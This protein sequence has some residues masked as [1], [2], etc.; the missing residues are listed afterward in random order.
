LVASFAAASFCAATAALFYQC[1]RF[2]LNKPTKY[3]GRILLLS[4]GLY[5]LFAFA[6]IVVWGFYLLILNTRDP[7]DWH[8]DEVDLSGVAAMC[9]ALSLWPAYGAILFVRL[10]LRCKAS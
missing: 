3:H 5:Q 7:R 4:A 10:H 2:S 1:A 8:G 9:F 6:G